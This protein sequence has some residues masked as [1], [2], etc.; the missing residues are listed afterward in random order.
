MRTKSAS[1]SGV[2]NPR[3]ILTVALFA[4][5]GSLGLLSWASSPPTSTITVPSAVGQTITV[6]WTGEIPP[7]ANATSDCTNLADT[8]AA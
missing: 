5:G 2:I 4:V 1:K 7:L 8:S 6:T 3:L